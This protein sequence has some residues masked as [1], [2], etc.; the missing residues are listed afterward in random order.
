MFIIILPKDCLCPAP[1]DLVVGQSKHFIW[2]FA[3]VKVDIY[4]K[5]CPIFNPF[6]LLGNYIYVLHVYLVK[7][8]PVN[9]YCI[10]NLQESTGFYW[11][12]RQFGIFFL[13]FPPS[14]FFFFMVYIFFSLSYI[15]INA[16]FLC[17]KDNQR[18]LLEI[19]LLMF[20][21]YYG[22]RFHENAT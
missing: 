17:K 13:L 8:H 22:S 9:E 11:V 19:C 7:L 16:F 1:L 21:L 5:I 15:F 4:C 2:K 12:G 14:N 3:A 20:V 6:S 18:L 10:A